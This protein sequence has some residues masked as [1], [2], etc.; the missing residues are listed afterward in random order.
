MSSRDLAALR[1]L[2]VWI[3]ISEA[4]PGGAKLRWIMRLLVSGDAEPVERFR[5]HVG[6]G[7]TRGHLL[8]PLGRL[9]ELLTIQMIPTRAERQPG[10]EVPR[11]KKS[12]HAVVD[13][14]ALIHE[15]NGRRPCNKILS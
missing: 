14:A 7:M 1:P 11:L 10:H 4:L 15:H 12:L 9:V 8:K 13:I 3:G 2:A 5:S 6:T